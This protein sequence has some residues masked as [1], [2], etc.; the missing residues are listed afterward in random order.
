MG[1]R[2]IEPYGG[3]YGRQ[4]DA[5]WD[6][7]PTEKDISH[8]LEEALLLID[9]GSTLYLQGTQRYEA[10]KVHYASIDRSVRPEVLSMVLEMVLL[11]ATLANIEM[12]LGL[13]C[14]LVGSF[15]F[16]ETVKYRHHRSAGRGKNQ[17]R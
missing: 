8:L 14:S 6:E 16:E 3:V 11:E 17:R 2:G 7:E 1:I 9:E 15:L 12:R 5:E 13:V 4:T 10:V